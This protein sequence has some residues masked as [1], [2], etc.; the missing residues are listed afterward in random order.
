MPEM[1]I[2]L[3]SAVCAA[4]IAFISGL[5]GRVSFAIVLFR[6]L[7][8]GGVFGVFSFGILMLLKRFVPE[9]FEPAS[10]EHPGDASGEESSPVA[11]PQQGSR[12]D[13]VLDGEETE[14]SSDTEDENPYVQA[15]GQDNDFIEEVREAESEDSPGMVKKAAGVMEKDDAAAASD[16][17][18]DTYGDLSDVDTLPDLDEFSNSFE[19]TASSQEDDSYIENHKA[20]KTVEMLE[21][22]HDPATVAKAVRTI[23]RR[24]QEG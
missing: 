7:L 14:Y 6:T 13:I 24:D 10:G 2:V 21:G 8:G 3:W 1:K 12:V 18:L 20:D 11:Y 9:I 19:N 16:D 17:I 4:A 22:K 15:D 5:F 23:I